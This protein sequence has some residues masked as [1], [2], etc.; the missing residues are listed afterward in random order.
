MPI[1]LTAD[2][3]RIVNTCGN[4]P[5]KSRQYKSG[6]FNIKGDVAKFDVSSLTHAE[7]DLKMKE[8]YQKN[9]GIWNCLACDHS[10]TDGGNMRKHVEIHLDGLS[11]TCP[12]C[13]KEFRSKNILYLHTRKIHK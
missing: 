11:Y 4:V 3:K 13:Q 10:A 8:L 2:N 6:A 1:Q 12:L 5:V 9:D 7:I